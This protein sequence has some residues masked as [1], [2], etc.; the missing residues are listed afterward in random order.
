M[1]YRTI[2]RPGYK[3][4]RKHQSLNWIEVP[5]GTWFYSKKNR[6][7]YHYDRGVFETHAAW[8]PQP[9]LI[10]ENPWKFY[11]HHHLKVPSDDIVLAQVS[12]EH[13]FI[14]LQAVYL[15]SP[16]WRTVT[17][18]REIE[19]LLLVR[20]MRH[21]QQ[22]SIEEGRVH[23][24]VMQSIM[25]NHGTDLLQ[26]VLDGTLSLAEATDE[27]IVAWI[28]AV[29]QTERE[30]KL[31]PIT[32]YIS[33]WEFQEAFA[34]VSERT[35]SSPSGINYT[36]WK[37]LA[38]DEELAGWLS[39]M[40]SLPF[41]HGFV[42]ERWTHSIDVMLEK[43]PGNRKIHMLRIIGL[44]EADFNTALKILFAKKMMTNAEMAGL[45]N[46]RN[47]GAEHSEWLLTR[48]CAI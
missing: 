20:N 31:P 11:T 13:D 4:P 46:E 1:R 22:A 38:R 2:A 15:P 34:K 44:L 7:I 47:G 16:I 26:E 25:Q 8:S 12:V 3:Y 28:N 30:R 33:A 21:L 39:I 6:E 19:R 37:C 36:I 27:V 17:D 42:N 32:G 35:S 5:E 14:F 45:N 43:K 24:P 29:K 9:G 41:Q 23:H 10:P 18:P 48:R 40:M